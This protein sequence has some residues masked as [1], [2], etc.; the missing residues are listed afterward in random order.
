VAAEKARER[1]GART[2]KV[3]LIALEQVKKL[4]LVP[5]LIVLVGVNGRR[6]GS[7]L[8]LV[9]VEWP[10]RIVSKMFKFNTDLSF[11]LTL[12]LKSKFF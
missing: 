3:K 11:R 10:H 5:R 12:L 6:L 9:A 8:L 2:E 4:R 7:V 1:D